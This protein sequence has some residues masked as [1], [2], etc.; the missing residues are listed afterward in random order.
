MEKSKFEKEV[1]FLFEEVN[2]HLETQTERI[3]KEKLEKEMVEILVYKKQ[4]EDLIERAKLP[5]R[6]AWEKLLQIVWEI[7]GDTR[8]SYQDTCDVGMNHCYRCFYQ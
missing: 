2:L 1:D 8:N 6:E 4:L 3:K 5:R 7:F